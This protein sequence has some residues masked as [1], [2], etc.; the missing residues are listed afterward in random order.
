MVTRRQ[1]IVAVAAAS[2]S[3][4]RGNAGAVGRVYTVGSNAQ[5]QTLASLPK[6]APGDTVEIASGTY[7]EMKLWDSHGTENLP[8]TIR[9]VGPTRPVIDGTGLQLSGV[10]DV[11]RALFQISGSHTV[12][13]NIA[14]QNGRNNSYNGAGIRV[15]A[16]N[17][18]IIK[19]CKVSRCDMGMMSDENDLLSIE[20]C[21][22][23]F[24]G[25]PE[26]FNGYSH[27]LYLGGRRTRIQFCW[28]HDAICGMNFK[29]RGLYTELLYNTVMDSNEGEFSFVDGEHTHL[30]N[31]NVVMI[32]NI[33]RSKPNRTGNTQ[34]Y[35]DFGQDMGGA[36]NGIL[37]L[38]Q[39]TLVAGSGNIHFLQSSSAQS[40][41]AAIANIFTGSR[42]LQGLSLGSISGARNWLSKDALFPA[43][44][45]EN[46]LGTSPGFV[47]EQ[48]YNFHLQHGSEC[49]QKPGMLE[50]YIDNNGTLHVSQMKYSV[51][52]PL[53]A[54]KLNPPGNNYI[55]ALGI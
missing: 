44:F 16:C 30:P 2:L 26:H 52:N 40:T 11:P 4:G 8:I 54:S 13:E 35:I 6:L 37:Y 27:N 53:H 9:G 32:G 15:L 25:N 14:F 17:N 34:K 31:S 5:F 45:V 50:E 12:I 21:E 41:I 18:T 20:A 48:T 1:F 3:A 43:R 7:N 10:G 49:L 33:V 36:R 42:N 38:F 51:I 29:T 39:N 47:S 22:F 19:G 24:N 23:A 46:I 55:G 28:I